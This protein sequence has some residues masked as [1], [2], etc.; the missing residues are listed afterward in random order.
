M[1]AMADFV[2]RAS[3]EL[4]GLDILI[5]I[6][7]VHHTQDIEATSLEDWRRVLDVNLLAPIEISRRA[8]LRMQAGGA[9]VNVSSVL[10]QVAAP[11]LAALEADAELIVDRDRL[12]DP[13]HRHRARSCRRHRRGHV[14]LAAHRE[15]NTAYVRVSL[16]DPTAS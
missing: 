2:E 4:G 13:A 11:R 3:R 1:W 5:N 9:I 7:R 16:T 10:G 8:V 6:A 14:P 12:P 15:R